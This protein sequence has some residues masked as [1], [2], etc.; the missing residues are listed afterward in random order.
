LRYMNQ[1]YTMPTGVTIGIVNDIATE[2]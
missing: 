1:R 2:E